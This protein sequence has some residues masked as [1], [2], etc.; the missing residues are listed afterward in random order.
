V[1][2][3][4]PHRHAAHCES[5]TM[6]ALL[7]SRGLDLSEPMVFGLGGGLFFIHVPFVK[8]GG[9]PLTAYRAAPR[10]II[11]TLS[12]RLKVRMRYERFRDPAA[13]ARRLDELLEQGVPVGIQAN[14]FWLTYF[15]ADMR[16]QYNGHNM[17]AYGKRDNAYL[18]SDPV[19]ETVVTCNAEDLIRARFARGGPFPPK[20]LI[21]YPETRPAA[22]DLPPLVHQS[23]RTTVKQMIDTPFPLIG[24]RGIR[25]LANRLERWPVKFGEKYAKVNVGNLVRMQE[26]IGTGGAGFRFLYAAFLQEAAGVL[27]KPALEEISGALTQTGDRW[28]EFAV[29]GAQHCKGRETGPAVY[30]RLAG[31]LRECADREQAIYSDLKKAL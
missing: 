7:R 25:Y 12:G 17:V 29:L 19:F 2:V 1:T 24:V 13:G 28:R 8:L 20:G 5:G 15:P 11:K 21:Y 22:P 30:A 3:D 27:G 18:L 14:A 4:F 16:F 31:I 26:E 6:A 10:A 9:L 23:I